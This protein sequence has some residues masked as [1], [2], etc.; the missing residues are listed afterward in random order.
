MSR[1]LKQIFPDQ[2]YHIY[3]RSVAHQPIFL[4]AGDFQRFL[5]T[6]SFYRFA[7]PGS[8]YSHFARLNPEAQSI[9]QKKLE[10]NCKKLV[11]IFAFC[12]MPNHFHFLLKGL[13]D[14][15]VQRFAANFQNSYAKY[16]NTKRKRNGALF[17]E[18]FKAVEVETDEQFLHVSRYIH[19]NPFS[20][21]VV[22]DLD[23][24]KVYPWSSLSGYLGI[25]K[26]DFLDQE[27]LEG[28]FP[29]KKELESFIF[30]RA[31]YQRRLEGIK[32]LLF[33]ES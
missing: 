32:H 10:S 9:F 8:R 29:N 6:V 27:L 14:K 15:G 28:Y 22:N 24:L 5:C 21:L 2:I 30:D 11:S 7:S 25:N 16:F 13:T 17:Q 31:D 19:L 23:D 18:M 33:E 26:I 3:N 12:L 20:S 1:R 4:G